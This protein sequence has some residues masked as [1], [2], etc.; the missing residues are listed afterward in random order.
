MTLK[1]TG[2]TDLLQALEGMVCNHCP[3][4]LAPVSSRWARQVLQLAGQV[5]HTRFEHYNIDHVK[6]LGTTLRVHA[7]VLLQEGRVILR[8]DH[9]RFAPV[10]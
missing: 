7:G 1:T 3:A 9:G 10:L 6:R 4:P 2:S 5:S 8:D